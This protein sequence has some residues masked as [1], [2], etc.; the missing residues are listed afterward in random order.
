MTR[1]YPVTIRPAV[2]L[3]AA[4]AVLCCLLFTC[5]FAE[6]DA[7]LFTWRILDNGTVCI[8]G[9]NSDGD[10]AVIPETIEG[11]PVTEIGNGAFRNHTELQDVTMPSSL[12]R[13]GAEAFEGCSSY[14]WVQLPLGVREIG[15]RAFRGSGIFRFSP[16]RTVTF[17]GE[18]V[19]ADTSLR[20]VN[21][22][23]FTY[24]EEWL[25][26]LEN[27][28]FT[29]VVLDIARMRFSATLAAPGEQVVCSASPSEEG[30]DFFRWQRST[31]GE[32]WTDCQE[33][34]VDGEYVFTASAESCNCWYRV[35]AVDAT[36]EYLTEPV[37]IGYLDQ[38]PVPEARVC[39]TTVSLDWESI[40]EGVVY[41]LYMTGPDGRE[42]LLAEE[43]EYL[44]FDAD[45]LEPDTEYAFRL[46]ASFGDWSAEG[47]TVT[48]RTEKERTGTVCRA[49]LI[50]E[51][52]YKSRYM[53]TV[54]SA[55]DLKLLSE[56]LGTVTDPEGNPYSVVRKTDLSKDEIR[57]AIR[58]AFAGADKDD[59]SLFFIATH[60]LNESD[61]EE[62][63]SLTAYNP[64][65]NKDEYI[66]DDEL[67]EWLAEIP[68]KKIVFLE[69]CSSGSNIYSAD[70]QADYGLPRS[71][72]ALR[73]ES[74]LVLTSSAHMEDSYAYDTA[75]PVHT[76]FTYGL[77]RGVGLSG[78][79]PCDT[80]GDGLAS[81]DEL[82]AWLRNYRDP[83]L[84]GAVQH[85]QMYPARS[86]DPLFRRLGD[87]PSPE[88]TETPAPKPVP[89]TGDEA[90]LALWALCVLAGLC[91]LWILRCRKNR[92]PEQSEQVG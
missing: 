20:F 29:V 17:I 42:T 33:T 3:I 83:Y 79:M 52:N 44:F 86:D 54:D 2:R 14:K 11:R 77:T 28:D 38:C 90:P 51:V 1:V 74:F 36:G 13:I 55:G 60:G 21:V 92:R 26:S 57:R 7:S 53:Q 37:R 18:D 68:G 24:S 5:A 50:G 31:D 85:A 75:E 81:A 41:S 89:K 62:A 80:D 66:T 39:G 78:K 25:N 15:A 43:T 9:W 10:T 64:E 87:K 30:I 71:E 61:P 4:A 19:C 73:R 67:A 84:P 70:E 88:P 63:G 32:N 72:G 47:K 35:L 6:E 23:R 69:A 27:P 22:F 76:L 48:V 82:L 49:L 65:T 16:P 56:M 46:K 12:I 91:G 59:V 58:D 45:S 40:G 34:P 8:T